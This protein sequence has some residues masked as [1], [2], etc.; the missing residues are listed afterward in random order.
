[1]LSGKPHAGG[2]PVMKAFQ[3]GSS[4]C[5]SKSILTRNVDSVMVQPLYLQGKEVRGFIVSSYTRCTQLTS[6]K[7]HHPRL[8]VKRRSKALL[9][10]A[11]THT[12]HGNRMLMRGQRASGTRLSTRLVVIRELI[13]HPLISHVV[14]EYAVLSSSRPIRLGLVVACS[15]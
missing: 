10:R 5:E 8:S 4:V 11:L 14:S 15:L 12:K 6:L 9:P 1:M 2:L 3:R 7:P 13:A